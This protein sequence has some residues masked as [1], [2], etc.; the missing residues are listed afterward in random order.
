M[1]AS[2]FPT[3]VAGFP[4]VLVMTEK[5][6]FLLLQTLYKYFELKISSINTTIDLVQ[7]LLLVKAN[8]IIFVVSFVLFYYINCC[9]YRK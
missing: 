2:F 6:P 7:R 8:A 4:A 9:V 3:L 5:L 1:L